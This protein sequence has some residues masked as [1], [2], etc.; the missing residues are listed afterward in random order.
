MP[1]VLAIALLLAAPQMAPTKIAAPVEATPAPATKPQSA[2]GLTSTAQM[3]VRVVVVDRCEVSSSA[4]VACDA[5]RP[6][7]PLAAG[8]AET[9]SCRVVIF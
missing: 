3:L 4:P 1:T 8:R 2:V 6:I 7:T 9:G 5:G